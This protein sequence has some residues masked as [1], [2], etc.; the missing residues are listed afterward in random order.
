MID[1]RYESGLSWQP[2]FGTYPELMC[3]ECSKEDQRDESRS[4]AG[5]KEIDI[6][7]AAVGL[8]GQ[9]LLTSH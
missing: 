1:I 6:C 4:A 5:G 3:S 8:R 7:V 2:S 9:G